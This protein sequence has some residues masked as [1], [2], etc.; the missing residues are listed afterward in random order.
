MWLKLS[1]IHEQ[2]SAANKLTLTTKF[3]EHQMAP[4]E[5]AVQHMAKIE[6]LANQLKDVGENVSDVMIM[7][8]ILGTLPPKFNAFISAWDSMAEANQTLANLRERIIREESRLS[9]ADEVAAALAASS[10]SNSGE[11]KN[12]EKN[13]SPNAETRDNSYVASDSDSANFSAFVVASG[14]EQLSEASSN[15]LL[16]DRDAGSSR[17]GCDEQLWLLNSGASRHYSCRRDWFSEFAPLRNENVY[18]GDNSVLRVEG[19]GKIPI[20]RL[21]DGKWLKGEINNVFFAPALKRNLLSAG[22]CTSLGQTIVF[23][24]D[25][26]KIHSKDNVLIAE[27]AK[28]PNNLSRMLIRSGSKRENYR[29]ISVATGRITVS[30]N[31]F[32]NEDSFK[33]AKNDGVWFPIDKVSEK[34]N[35]PQIVEGNETVS[36]STCDADGDSVESDDYH[37]VHGNGEG[38]DNRGGYEL[39]SRESLH[40]PNRYVCAVECSGLYDVPKNYRDTLSRDDSMLWQ[41]A[42]DEELNAH[43]K[44]KSWDVVKLPEGRSSIGFKWVFKVKNVESEGKRRYKERLCAQGFSQQPDID[45]DEIF[46]PVVRYESIRT[47]LSVA[48]HESLCLI[49]FDASTAYLNSE[50][51]ESIY[52]R[53]PDGLGIRGMEI[54]H[55]PGFIFVNQKSYISRVLEKFKMLD[56]NPVKTPADSQCRLN[57]PA[58]R[59]KL[60]VPYRELVGSLLYL[61]IIP[62]S[63]IAYVVGVVREGVI[64]TIYVNTNNQ[65]ADILTKALVNDKFESQQSNLNIVKGVPKTLK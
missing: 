16:L 12:L 47:L 60:H 5:S 39:R 15:S 56:A 59:T 42:I 49:Q 17:E 52:M 44:N 22:T 18:L 50:L 1:S 13:D 25:R 9:S 53:I 54:T 61:A 24:G 55:E 48:V 35:Q 33:N 45:Y 36:A 63:D 4:G 62:R 21:V 10:I 34:A 29:L 23:T 20:T 38:S 40:A 26:A 51:N 58:K 57:A 46:S 3:H 64:N 31:V 8:K 65:C 19:I 32:F 11:Q 6:N 28:L 2:K 43:A 30:R 37:T 14:G 7:A 27:G 41:K